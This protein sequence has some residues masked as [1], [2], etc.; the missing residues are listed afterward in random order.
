MKKILIAAIAGI[1]LAGC[2]TGTTHIIGQNFQDIDVEKTTKKNTGC[3][4]YVPF[5]LMSGPISK[6]DSSVITI[7]KQKG[8]KTITYAD[9]SYYGI[10][11]F[12]MERCYT[13]YGY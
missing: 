7:A 12:F 4:A 3:D 9:Y 10:L 6:E 8:I 1:S 5:L 2:N 13:V 11:P